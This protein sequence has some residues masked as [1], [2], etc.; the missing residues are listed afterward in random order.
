[1]AQEHPQTAI[2]LH[3]VGQELRRQGKYDEALDHY[4]RALALQRTILGSKHPYT[5]RKSVV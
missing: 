1:M 3:A 5:D 4:N 2:A